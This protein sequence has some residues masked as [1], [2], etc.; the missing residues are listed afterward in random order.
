MRML[1]FGRMSGCGG[2]RTLRVGAAALAVVG[3]LG[4]SAPAS[5]QTLIWSVVPSPNPAVHINVLNGVSCVSVNRCMAVGYHGN[6]FISD[7]LVESW[8]GAS[9]SVVPS[10]TP[11]AISTLNGVSCVSATACTAVGNAENS[12]GIISTL[13]ESWN[14]ASWSVVPSP[15]PGTGGISELTS[16]SCISADACTAVGDYAATGNGPFDTLVESWNGASWSVVPSP[17][18]T[19]DSNYL[20][21]VSCVSADTCTAVGNDGAVGSVPSTLVESW[22]GTSWSVVHSPSPNPGFGDYLDGVSC[23]S[24]TA[25]T[26]VGQRST[27]DAGVGKTLVES[28]NGTSWSIMPS[29]NRGLYSQLGSVSC[30]SATACTAAGTSH[31]SPN[32]NGTAIES[33]NGTSWSVV[34]SPNPGS[35]S[36]LNGVSCASATA[37]T[38]V[39]YSASTKYKTLI[40]A[41]R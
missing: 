12:S 40:E 41:S 26:A 32:L 39:G 38:A 8:N 20:V 34:P 4:V 5:A 22:D 14:G 2:R 13:V 18:P 15:S 36:Q 25:C 3:M 11:A 19:T 10:P 35:L 21:S 9:W 28:W 27:T 16:V 30:A 24:A 1:R 17:N 29:P 33:W 37:C 31:R 23:V 7:T 6:R